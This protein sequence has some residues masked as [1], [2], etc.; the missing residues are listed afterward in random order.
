MKL[1][2]DEL[3]EVV[4]CIDFATNQMRFLGNVYELP[5][6]QNKEKFK[7]GYLN[8]LV[9]LRNKIVAHNNRR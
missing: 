3:N 9:E 2:D 1:S 8:Y 5:E 7:Y 4:R 6:R